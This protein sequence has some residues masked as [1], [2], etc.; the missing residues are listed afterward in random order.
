VAKRLNRLPISALELNVSCPHVREVG[1]EIGQNEEAIAEVVSKVKGATRKPIFVKL[2]PNVTD[3]ARMAE[4]AERAGASGITAINTVKA[5]AIDVEMGTPILG[6]R[7]GGLSGPA[8][9]PV[10]V[11]CVYEIY[12]AVRIPIIGCGGITRWQDAAELLMAGASALQVGTAIMHN[13][14]PVFRELLT[15]LKSF[16][17]RRGLKT[18]REFIGSAHRR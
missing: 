9:K 10:A 6:G 15:G 18:V 5:M 4:A 17:E 13:D 12:D 3:I 2:T 14:L 1:V 7:F 16:L 11:R 8:I